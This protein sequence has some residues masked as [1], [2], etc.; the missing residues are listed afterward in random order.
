MVE[1]LALPAHASTAEATKAAMNEYLFTD[2]PAPLAPGQ[3]G[4]IPC[5]CYPSW[6]PT[7]PAR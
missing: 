3:P 7:V 2:V 1:A 4:R 5:S 6:A